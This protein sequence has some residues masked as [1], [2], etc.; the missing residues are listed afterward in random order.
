MKDIPRPHLDALLMKWRKDASSY[1]NRGGWLECAT[2]FC[3]EELQKI[4]DGDLS[5]IERL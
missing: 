1:Y 2:R 5:P 3:I 4:M